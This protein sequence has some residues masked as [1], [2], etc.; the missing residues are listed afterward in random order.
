MS[1]A[2]RDLKPENVDKGGI[3]APMTAADMLALD[4]GMLGA[5]VVAA[6]SVKDPRHS[7]FAALGRL[8]RRTPE[9]YCSQDLAELLRRPGR[10]EQRWTPQATMF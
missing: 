10:D 3:P 5:L 6:L 7:N 1:A 9:P 2:D 8:I 4:D